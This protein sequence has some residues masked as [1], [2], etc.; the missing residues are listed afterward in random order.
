MPNQ[1]EPQARPAS[2]LDHERLPGK[3]ARPD[4]SAAIPDG[5]AR[6]QLGTAQLSRQ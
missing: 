2:R 4:D 3:P 6:W 1:H 5:S